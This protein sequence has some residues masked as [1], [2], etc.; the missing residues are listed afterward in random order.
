MAS[1]YSINDFDIKVLS[2]QKEK[3]NKISSEIQIGP[4]KK[5]MG[6]TL[7]N[8]IRRTL[9]IN[10]EGVAITSVHL[11]NTNKNVDMTTFITFTSLSLFFLTLCVFSRTQKTVAVQK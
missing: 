11:Y 1:L 8:A 9:Y 10:L 7:G 2:Y 4:L 3:D 5:N 6:I